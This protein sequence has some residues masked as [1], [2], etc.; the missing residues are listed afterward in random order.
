MTLEEA[1]EI[2]SLIKFR[3][4]IFEVLEKN[5]VMYLRARY[6]EADIITGEEEMQYT[7]K[8]QLSEHMVKSELVQTA[9]KCVLTSAEHTTREHFLYKGERVYGPHFDVDALYEIAKA[10][11]LDYRGKP[12]KAVTA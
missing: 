4:Y 9:F 5:G 8:W 12:K 10:K 11:R 1:R 3:N 2:V 6:L 7:R